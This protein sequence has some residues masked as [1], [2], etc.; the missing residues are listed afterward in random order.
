MCMVRIKIRCRFRFRMKLWCQLGLESGF[1]LLIR[2]I[3]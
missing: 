2:V 3:V 1:R